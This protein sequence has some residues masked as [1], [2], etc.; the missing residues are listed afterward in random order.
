MTSP[1]INTKIITNVTLYPN[2]MNNNIYLNLKKNLEKKVIGKCFEDYGYISEIYG[3][4]YG[5]ED[6]VI[7]AENF[8]ASAEYKILF[9]CRL[10]IPLKKKQIICE[11]G[12]VNKL[13]V[14]VTNGPILIVITNNRINDK[15][16]FTDNNN[17]LRY[18]S[19][20]KSYILKS[21]DFVKVTII[22]TTFNN[23]DEKIKAIGFLDD[24]ANN[25]EIKQFYQ[26]LYNKEGEIVDLNEYLKNKEKK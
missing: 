18:R 19:E 3:I 12:R 7:E 15:I 21:K 16:F 1:Y 4:E 9:S 20:N 13:L 10:C 25:K 26:E 22:T 8:S 6:N 14:T 24:M 23:G 5:P 2:Q 17:N 11:V